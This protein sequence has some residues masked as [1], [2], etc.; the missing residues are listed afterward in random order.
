VSEARGELVARV[1]GNL[2]AV[3]ARIA[4]V[5][6]DPGSVSVVAVTKTFGPPAVEAA[7]AAGL[8][9]VAESYAKELV[10]TRNAVTTPVTWHYL[11][12]LQ[13]NKLGA[14]VTRV[15]VFQSVASATDAERLG[16]RAA[17]AR[18]Y[19][20]VDVTGDPGRLGCRR[21]DLDGVVGAARD[22]GLRV[23]GLMC[24]A[25]PDPVRAT[26]EFGWLR[27][28]ADRSGLEGCSMGM[29]GDFELACA[30]GSTMVRLGTILFGDRPKEGSEPVA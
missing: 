17:G 27:G 22:A 7:I 6:T 18:C 4:A 8:T 21:A 24:V 5:R 29:S 15:D 11:G 30:L 16:H 13:G 9:D 1:A 20:Q 14:L 19:V 23:E 10:A 28:A 12:A 26:E 2:A 25:S 3:R